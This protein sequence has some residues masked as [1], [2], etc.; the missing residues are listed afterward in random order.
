MLSVRS[1]CAAANA[2]ATVLPM[3]WA[4]KF[5]TPPYWDDDVRHTQPRYRSDA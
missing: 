3:S 1:G 4:I 2:S 5:G